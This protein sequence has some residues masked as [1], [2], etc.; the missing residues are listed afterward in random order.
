MTANFFIGQG[1]PLKP[2]PL[3]HILAVLNE[4]WILKHT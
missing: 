1:F 4:V 3:E 2:S